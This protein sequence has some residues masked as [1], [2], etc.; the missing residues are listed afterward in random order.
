MNILVTGVNGQL[1]H[2]VVKL[3]DSKEHIVTGVDRKEMDIT[4]EEAVKGKI[5]EV[6]PDVI[7]HCAAYT[8][9]DGAEND[10]ETAYQVNALGTK[11]LAQAAKEIGAKMLF[12]STDYVFEGNASEPYEV[13]HPTNPIGAYGRTKL[14]GE[15]F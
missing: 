4:N 1:G 12:V 3:L 11:Y 8:N 7:V 9:V 10:E 5:R 15:N 14:A 6:K 13:D 2:D